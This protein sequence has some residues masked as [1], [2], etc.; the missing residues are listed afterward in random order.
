MAD[1][2]CMIRPARPAEAAALSDLA[3]R[4]KAYWG[5]DAAFMEACRAELTYTPGQVAEGGVVVAERA[6]RC[7]GFYVLERRS[8]AEVELEALFVDPGHIGRGIGR[9]LLEH[10]RREAAA[11]GASRM[12]VQSDPH[13][14]PFYRAAGGVLTGRR[15]SGSIPGRRLPT[16]TFDLAPDA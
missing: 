2:P 6:G 3:F 12:I 16:F 14:A 10:A 5:Y 13:A 15:P 1:A 8:P 4:S 11:W 9:A 7:V